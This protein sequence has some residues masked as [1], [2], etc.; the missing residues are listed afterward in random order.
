MK[1]AIITIVY[2]DVGGI[3]KTI[4]S[5]LGQTSP[6]DEYVVIDGGSTDGTVDVIKEYERQLTYFVSEPD[7]GIYNAMNKGWRNAT[8][9]CYILFCNSSDYLEAN[10]VA[11]YRAS[12]SGLANE[13]DIFHGLLRFVDK[14]G[15]RYIQGRSSEYLAVSMIEHP[16]CAVKKSVFK[17]LGGFSEAYV[18]ASDYDFI[19][20][21]K[22]SG[23]SFKFVESVISNF[24]VS[25]ISSTSDTGA[26]ESLSIKRS[27]GVITGRDYFLRV[28]L[29]RIKGFV[30]RFVG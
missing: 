7:S 11:L 29:L 30:K 20:R 25:G 13:V 23:F 9:D 28:T 22:I 1:I 18:S 3:R 10:A 16:T 15:V 5:V 14:K 24:D 26:R 8:D 17:K 21:A 2:N 4:E 19:T 6:V 12:F 27:N